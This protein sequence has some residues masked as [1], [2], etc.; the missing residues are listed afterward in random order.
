M[1]PAILNGSVNQIIITALLY[2]R[3][4]N[5]SAA[6]ASIVDRTMTLLAAPS[7][8]LREAAADGSQLGVP[9]GRR[10]ASLRRRIERRPLGDVELR[11]ARD[12]WRDYPLAGYE[13]ETATKPDTESGL[14]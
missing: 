9:G 12:G 2:R 6:A 14:R 7:L 8:S 13:Q 1:K 10:R 3:P 5:L 4:R 11:L